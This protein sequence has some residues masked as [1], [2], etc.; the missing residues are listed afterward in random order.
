MREIRFRAWDKQD[1]RMIVDEQ[2]FIPLK[3]TNKGVL[4]LSPLYV[5][6][7]WEIIPIER[8]EIMQYTG[9]KDKNGVEIYEGD[10]VETY[11]ELKYLNGK[12]SGEFSTSRYVILLHEC[13]WGIKE[14]YNSRWHKDCEYS[15]NPHSICVSVPAKYYKAIGNIHDNP[16]LLEVPK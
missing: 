9:L 11:G 8:F 4:K 6:N 1:K 15:Q 7:L 5:E 14:I 10:I 16:E 12:G 13:G 3:V 2:G